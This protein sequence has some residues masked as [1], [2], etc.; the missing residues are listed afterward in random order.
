MAIIKVVETNILWDFLSV[1]LFIFLSLVLIQIS[2]MHIF[3]SIFVQVGLISGTFVGSGLL[4]ANAY[5]LYFTD[6]IF[7][8]VLSWSFFVKT[9]SFI[10]DKRA[11]SGTDKP[12][13]VEM[14][15][16]KGMQSFYHKLM[17]FISPVICYHKY[18][19]NY[20]QSLVI[21]FR[22]L[23]TKF[24]VSFLCL[25]VNNIVTV[26]FIEPACSEDLSFI[27]LIFKLFPLTFYMNISLYYMV[28]D[29][30]LAALA[31]ITKIKNRVFYLDWWNAETIYEF[32]D[33][34]CLLITE[35][36]DTYLSK[37]IYGRIR[38]CFHTG[39]LL[40]LLLSVFGQSINLK[41]LGVFVFIEGF[42]FLL[43][44]LKFIQNNYLVH[45]LSLS[46]TPVIIALQVTYS[47]FE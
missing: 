25:M 33:K 3:S 13:W 29:N 32:Q 31:E 28:M 6:R 1:F 34:W 17:F 23:F 11:A 38:Q 16:K 44:G 41:S 18:V 12:E 2:H 46:F 40:C 9:V 37:I 19:E 8:I 42:T 7:I 15:K 45:I 26:K 47:I 21:H 14:E 22:Y 39:I 35:F 36:T 24:L 10:L 4:I 27:A 5:Q 20:D 43:G 30:I